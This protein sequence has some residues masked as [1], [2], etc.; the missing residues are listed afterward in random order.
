FNLPQAL[1]G[2]PNPRPHL[3]ELV[4]MAQLGSAHSKFVAGWCFLS[5][6]EL[7]MG[8]RG[9]AVGSILEADKLNYARAQL[10][11]ANDSRDA[12]DDEQWRSARKRA[13][14]AA[15]Q[16]LQEAVEF[17]KKYPSR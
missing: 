10:W 9:F 3:A 5:Y 15:A 8:D 2:A 14:L 4:K 1:N 13:E 17:L 6:P 16:G 11:V 7:G 12:K